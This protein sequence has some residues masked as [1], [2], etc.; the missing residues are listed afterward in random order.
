MIPKMSGCTKG[1]ND[2][3]CVFFYK[4]WYIARKV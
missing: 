1:F 2:A 4:K 3:K